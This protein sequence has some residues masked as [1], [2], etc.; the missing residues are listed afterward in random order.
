MQIQKYLIANQCI[1]IRIIYLFLKIQMY[2]GIRISFK[3]SPWAFVEKRVKNS[4]RLRKRKKQ[5]KLVECCK[6]ETVDRTSHGKFLGLFFWS[7]QKHIWR[8]NKKLWILK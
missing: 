5:A 3:F 4:D 7:V 8:F 6:L 2:I 1:A